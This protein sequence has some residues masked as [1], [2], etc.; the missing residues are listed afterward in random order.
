MRGNADAQR[1]LDEYDVLSDVVHKM[2]EEFGLEGAINIL[3][4]PELSWLSDLLKQEFGTTGWPRDNFRA[5]SRKECVRR[6]VRATQDFSII[7]V[8]KFLCSG[9]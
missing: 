2:L 4:H 6:A 9:A 3:G 7:R 1:L 8:S 5:V